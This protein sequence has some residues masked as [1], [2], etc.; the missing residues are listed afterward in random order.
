MLTWQNNIVF[1]TTE[2][3]LRKSL[4]TRI[5]D[6]ACYS[7]VIE[8]SPLRLLC[9]QATRHRI[10]Q[11]RQCSQQMAIAS[12]PTCFFS[13]Q[14]LSS[15]F[16]HDLV[17]SFQTVVDTAYNNRSHLQRSIVLCFMSQKKRIAL[18]TLVNVERAIST[19]YISNWIY[20]IQIL[21]TTSF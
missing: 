21:V 7:W 14:F 3:S 6:L 11:P 17:F 9:H 2:E 20:K 16:V 1:L 13:M 10:I 5:G 15:W 19:L 4:L 8:Y 18:V 12:S